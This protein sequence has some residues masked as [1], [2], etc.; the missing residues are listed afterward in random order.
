MEIRISHSRLR[1]SRTCLLLAFVFAAIGSESYAQAAPKVA[2]QGQPAPARI[3]E[4]EDDVSGAMLFLHELFPDINPKSKSIIQNN[5]DWRSS[6]GGIGAF[7]IDIC[8]PD[9]PSRNEEAQRDFFTRY[10][11][12]CSV[13]TMQAD[14]LMT[15]SQ[16]GPV[17]AHIFIWRPNIEKRRSELAALLV[18]HPNWSEAQVEEAMR[19]SGVK[20]GA[21]AHNDVIGLLHDA[22]PKLE[23]F[24]GKL[25]LDSMEYF[26]PLLTD[27]KL[28]VG[29][30][31][32]IK[33]HPSEQDFTKPRN[34]YTLVFNSFDGAFES[35]M[36]GPVAGPS[37]KP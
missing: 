15:G 20:Y 14:F 29:P 32:V 18:A 4:W 2:E 36:I 9:F 13:L 19:A 7:R 37:D 11:I 30:S 25:K 10:D 8:E 33:A 27:P 26:P 1:E 21:G 24:F 5:L 3:T 22:W 31:W 34:S 23:I 35:E 17:S 16:L 28:P 12:Q 6:P